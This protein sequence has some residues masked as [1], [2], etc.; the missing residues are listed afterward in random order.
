MRCAAGI[1]SAQT[2]MSKHLRPGGNQP[3]TERPHL[4]P[5]PPAERRRSGWNARANRRV[6]GRLAERPAG[7]PLVA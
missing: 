1:A 5:A 3:G 6:G 2:T 4:G 7:A